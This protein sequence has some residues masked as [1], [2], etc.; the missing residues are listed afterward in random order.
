MVTRST[1]RVTAVVALFGLFFLT[2]C[3]PKE[4]TSS[5]A[6]PTAKVTPFS[7]P[8]DKIAPALPPAHGTGRDPM[9]DDFY[10]PAKPPKGAPDGTVTYEVRAQKYNSEMEPIGG[11]STA[12]IDATPFNPAGVAGGV[13]PQGGGAWPYN[14][15][16]VLL[17]FQLPIFIQPGITVSV[18]ATFNTFAE[19]GEIL[20]CWLV[21]PGGMEIRGTRYGVQAKKKHAL[22]SANCAGNIGT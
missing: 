16:S 1:R 15:E 13:G 11:M 5:Q 19:E 14:K 9:D 7:K 22:L 10:N 21:G 3:V 6:E 18:I 8:N 4:D 20:I 17:P 12:F 2:G